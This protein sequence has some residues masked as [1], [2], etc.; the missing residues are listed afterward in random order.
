MALAEVSLK[1]Q[2]ATFP[3]PLYQTWVGK[4][5]DANA[6]I[7]LDYQG[8]GSGGGIKAI[9]DKTVDFAGSDVTLTK[10]EVDAAVDV[11][12]IPTVAGA[13]VAAYNLPDLKGDLNL[14]G[15]VIADIYL[16]KITKWNDLA[17]TALNPGATLPD[18]VITP[19]FRSDGS[20]TNAVFTSY[21]C[22]VSPAFSDTVGH[23][24]SVKLPAGV[25]QGAEKNNGVAQKVKDVPGALG[26][27][28]LV[29]AMSNKISAAAIQNVDGKFVKPTIASVVAAEASADSIPADILNQRGETAYP[30]AAFT[31]I[32]VHKELSYVGDK[33]KADALVNFLL[34]AEGDG[35]KL[36]GDQYYAPLPEAVATKVQQAISSLTFNGQPVK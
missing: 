16:G 36:A 25:G 10:K 32:L 1:G 26:Y 23:G 4:F 17:I 13:V 8:T 28:E 21:L 11:V 34:W 30:I 35:Q 27:I 29:Y 3:E 18:L 19:V 20:G 31:Y 5:H 33:A 7:K 6:D 9:I 15:P 24:K 12:Y 22:K 14:S 2:G